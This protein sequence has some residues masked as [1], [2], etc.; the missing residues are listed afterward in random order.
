MSPQYAVGFPCSELGD[1]LGVLLVGLGRIKRPERDGFV[2][3]LDHGAVPV[4]KRKELQAVFEHSRRHI[5]R[6]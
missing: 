1:N 2:P 6:A 4:F 5:N 3:E